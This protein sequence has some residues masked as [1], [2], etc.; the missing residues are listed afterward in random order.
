MN[1]YESYSTGRLRN[2]CSQESSSFENEVSQEPMPKHMAPPPSLLASHLLGGG[3]EIGPWSFCQQPAR[4]HL[5]RT[6]CPTGSGV[7]LGL[8][9]LKKDKGRSFW[10]SPFG[11]R[12]RLSLCTLSVGRKK[13]ML[14]LVHGN[15]GQR[16]NF[17]MGRCCQ[18]SSSLS[19]ISLY[20]FLWAACQPSACIPSSFPPSLFHGPKKKKCQRAEC[21]FILVRCHSNSKAT[22]IVL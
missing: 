3:T 22:K 6:K 15:P 4:L 17:K 5:P 18:E 16:G 11:M 14:A 20:L 21:I 1:R 13:S 7:R 10:L 12:Y 2:K 8:E 19:H 9:G